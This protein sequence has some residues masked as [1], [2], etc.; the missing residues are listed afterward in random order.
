MPSS[1]SPILT[2]LLSSVQ[3]HASSCLPD[4]PTWIYYRLKGLA[5]GH[6]ASKWWGKNL[7]SGGS[8]LSAC[9]L[10]HSWASTQAYGYKSSERRASPFQRSPNGLGHNYFII[11]HSRDHVP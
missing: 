6:T 9:V 2:S 7:N 1:I 3:S 10:N 5:P 4:D 11:S 8:G